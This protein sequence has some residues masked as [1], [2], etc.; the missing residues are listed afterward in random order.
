METLGRTS[1]L[2]LGESVGW[3][4][5]EILGAGASLELSTSTGVVALLVTDGAMDERSD[6]SDK[7]D[8]EEDSFVRVP[9]CVGIDS[10]VCGGGGGAGGDGG[11]MRVGVL[12]L[13]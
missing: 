5:R 1:H 10:V 6:W 11:R 9:S 12:L 2:R 4:G 13:V 7:D 8:N 3:L